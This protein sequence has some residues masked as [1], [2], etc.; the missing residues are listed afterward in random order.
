MFQCAWMG[1]ESEDTTAAYVSLPSGRAIQVYLCKK[2]KEDLESLG[3]V[4]NT[5]IKREEEK[6]A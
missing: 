4:K 5:V 3:E 1:C 6:V 2:H